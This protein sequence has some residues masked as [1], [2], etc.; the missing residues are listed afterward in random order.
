[1]SPVQTIRKPRIFGLL[2]RVILISI[3]SALLFMGI[4]LF[5]GIAIYGIRNVMHGGGFDMALA[6]RQIA[7]PVALAALTLG[8]FASLITEIR[9]FRRMKAVYREALS[10]R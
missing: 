4:G 9:Q 6:Y 1:M 5:V 10:H 3:L 8:F 2:A 7:I